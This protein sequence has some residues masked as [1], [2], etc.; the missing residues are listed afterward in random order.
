MKLPNLKSLRIVCYPD[1]VL[2][3]KCDPV[4]EFERG[5]RDLAER[6]IQLMR[7]AQ[8][9]GLAAPQVGVPIRLFVFSLSEEP[10]SE[11]VCMN[12]TLS[13]LDGADEKE[14]GCLS[15]PGAM[16]TMRRATKAVMDAFDLTGQPIQRVGH[17]LEAR[18]WQ[19][20][21]DHL[22]GRLI[23]DNMSATDEIGNRRAIKQL[24]ADYGG[25]QR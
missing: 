19:H 14:E 23:I 20:E 25:P 3:R 11:Q 15:I 24:V 7:Q 4:E 18:V 16:V 2:K 9:V 5:L 21:M 6:M 17:D 1:P 13:G 22:D 10:G 8:G 12:P